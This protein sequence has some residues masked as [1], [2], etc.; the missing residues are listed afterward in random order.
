[1]HLSAGQCN[2]LG[3]SILKY[4]VR[5]INFYSDI[6]ARVALVQSNMKSMQRISTFSTEIT[7]PNVISHFISTTVYA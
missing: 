5:T 6:I 4:A 1:M 7:S 3:I 2:P